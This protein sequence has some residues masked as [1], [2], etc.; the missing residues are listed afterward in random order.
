MSDREDVS[1]GVKDILQELDLRPRKSLGQNF[2]T[3]TTYLQQAVAAAEISKADWV[4]EVGAGPGTLT[5]RLAGA[6]GGVI[7]VELDQEFVSYLRRSFAQQSHVTV[8]HADILKTDMAD[9]V[10]RVS[11]QAQP[12]YKVVAN[13]PY[14]ITSALLRRLLEA[15]PPPQLAVLMLQW[16]VARRIV[17]SPPR[18]SLL[19]VSVQF[20]G[21]PRIVTKV[22]AGAFYPVPKV[23]SALLRVD[24]SLPEA[25][26]YPCR[27]RFFRVVRAGFSQRR[28]QLQN[29][30]TRELGLPKAE[31]IALLERIGITP[32]RRAETLSLAEWAIL[33]AAWEDWVQR[34]AHEPTAHPGG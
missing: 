19:A 28:K 14:Y 24:V 27:E 3:A 9:L 15:S 21:R 11:G 13:L 16:E 1:P 25:W 7:A 17:A 4:L 10:R 6:A 32:R 8:V 31:A 29:N 33:T 30:L 26:P 34:N 23:D 20:Y 2:L 12:R 18:M 22:P 5:T